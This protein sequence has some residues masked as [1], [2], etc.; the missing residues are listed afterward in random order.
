M[1]LR[2]QEL[3]R[4]CREGRRRVVLVPGPW[5]EML[6]LMDEDDS[7]VPSW[8]HC[9]LPLR[10][11]PGVVQGSLRAQAPLRRMGLFA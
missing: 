9:R 7:G 8:C 11:V 10:R 3:A 6:L 4:R 5:L 2:M 1:M